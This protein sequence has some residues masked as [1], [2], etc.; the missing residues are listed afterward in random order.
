LNERQPV[1]SFYDGLEFWYLLLKEVAA[2]KP[3]AG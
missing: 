1:K 3:L 2:A